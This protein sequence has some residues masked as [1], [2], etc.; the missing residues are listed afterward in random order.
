MRTHERKMKVTEDNRNK[1][2]R[3]DEKGRK[4]TINYLPLST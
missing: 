4:E 2:I 1:K 3:K